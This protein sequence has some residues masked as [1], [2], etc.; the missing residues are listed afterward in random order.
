MIRHIELSAKFLGRKFK[1]N[2]RKVISIM[3]SLCFILSQSMNLYAEG[4]ETNSAS[5]ENETLIE[6]IQSGEKVEITTQ[7]KAEVLNMLSIMSGDGKG[8]Y[9]LDSRL[10][11]SEAAAFI[12]KLL[13]KDTYIK[14]NKKLYMSTSFKDI[15]SSDWFLPYISYCEQNSIISGL[16]N[17]LYGP[18][19]PISEKAFLVLVMKSLGYSSDSNDFNWNTVYGSAYRVCLVKKP[20]YESKIE[21]NKEYT[22]EDVVDVLYNALS[23]KLKNSDITLLQ[24][25]TN[26]GVVTREIAY[27]TGLLNDKL[28]TAVM[29][30]T[31]QN[32]NRISI[33]FNEDVIPIALENLKIYE[34]K[35]NTKL[36]P[37]RRIIS[38]SDQ[39][40]VIETEDQ[41]VDKEYTLE[42]SNLTDMQGNSDTKLTSVFT[43]YKEKV[44]SS[45]IFK[46]SKVQ[47]ISKNE[48]YVF[49]THP[50][51][52]NCEIPTYYQ[53]YENGQQFV[54]G[55]SNTLK[56]KVLSGERN[57]V[58]ITI[59]DKQL[60][61]ENEYKVKIAGDLISLFGTKLNNG[62]GDEATFVPLDIMSEGFA[63]K[64]VAASNVNTV[65]LDFNKA[66][67]PVLAKQIYNF[68][69]TDS[70]N[71][72]IQIKKAAVID[73]EGK[74]VGITINGVFDK[75]KK[76]SIMINRLT[77]IDK[78]EEIVERT[79]EF[80]GDYPAELEFSLLNVSAVDS[81]TILLEFSKPIDEE[82]AENINYYGIIDVKNSYKSITPDNIYYSKDSPNEVKLYFKSANALKSGLVYKL[83]LS[84]IFKD[85]SGAPINKVTEVD[86]VSSNSANTKLS[87]TR[88][89]IISNDTIMVKFTGSEISVDNP[90]SNAQNY[91]V[92]YTLGTEAYKKIPIAVTYV[93]KDT[94]ILK[95][96]TLNA[97][98]NYTL[99]CNEIKTY[100]GDT[101]KLTDVQFTI[102]K[103]Q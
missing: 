89:V 86:F 4:N 6:D 103:G 83:R 5:S 61:S 32:K 10:N 95:F 51:N 57:A 100:A 75:T 94:V 81:Q 9:A 101:I 8:N 87:V 16:G 49:F 60:S 38:Q 98:L 43:G 76:Y 63:L 77:D 29:S 84:T 36:L 72:T 79:F 67:N 102:V 34:S 65:Q 58:A 30:V 21:D 93:D 11:R 56:V 54:E 69:I 27:S 45:D 55:K 40:L 74:S 33:I 88:A 39:K 35:R 31:P 17:G 18:S 64:N 24:K 68:N 15:K 25:L 26:D 52:E 53:I 28:I 1:M 19:Q 3:L 46:I 99:K 48:I 37:V 7:E 2:K 70:A 14:E 92:E 41:T 85:Y 23:T 22:R 90:N 71:N 66:V 42:F 44:V 73:V 59:Y 91:R 97:E 12:I 62:T 50:I 13:G 47:N 96:D 78:E 82:S 80:S 20:E